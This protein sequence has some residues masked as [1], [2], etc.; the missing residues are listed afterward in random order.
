MSQLTKFRP[1]TRG[2]RK[3]LLAMG[4]STFP[5]QKKNKRAYKHVTCPTCDKMLSEGD[6]II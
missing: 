3:Y 2:K 1:H 4:S 6:F 5:L